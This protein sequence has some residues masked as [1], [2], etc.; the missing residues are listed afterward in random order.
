MQT[1]QVFRWCAAA[2]LACVLVSCSYSIAQEASV[3]DQIKAL[4]DAHQQ[5]V[6]AFYKEYRAVT[7]DEERSNLAGNFPDA[8]KV[9]NPLMALVDS[10]LSSNDAA[11]AAMWVLR[12][13]RTEPSEAVVNV[14]K[15][16]A[17]SEGFDELALACMYGQSDAIGD[18]LDLAIEK[19]PNNKAKAAA[20]F[21][22]S[23]SL[24]RG[25]D[26]DEATQATQHRYLDLAVEHG[27]ELMLGKRS[28]AD[29]AASTIFELENLEIGKTAP[30]IKGE[31]IDGVEFA[32]S[33][34]RVNVVVIDFWGDW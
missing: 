24:S 31:D 21:A 11:T 2:V 5:K 28:I 6:D 7:T 29:S 26:P 10:D 33:E 22:R 18:A 9:A 32:L 1:K 20:A 3:A 30:D 19:N 25:G 16:Q 14:L 17:L 12:N 13:V 15:A 23:N 34:Y 27:A 4:T 8:G